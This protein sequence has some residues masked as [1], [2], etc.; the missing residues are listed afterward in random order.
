MSIKVIDFHAKW[1][2]PCKT[3]SPL[4]D[5]MKEK[6]GDKAEFVKVDIEV[7]ED[8]ASSYNISSVPTFLIVKDDVTIAESI[9]SSR[10]IEFEKFIVENI[11]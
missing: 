8:L 9:G 11:G 1:C 3:M 6:Y 2:G 7:D 5:K 4:F 10:P